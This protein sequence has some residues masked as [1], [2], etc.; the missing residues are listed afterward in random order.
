MSII[1]SDVE[2]Q[3]SLEKEPYTILTKRYKG[4]KKD[5]DVYR[6]FDSKFEKQLTNSKTKRQIGV[7]FIYKNGRAYL[8][9]PDY[10]TR[11]FHSCQGF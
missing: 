7:K 6:N 9:T 5:L 8:G 1:Y 4:I 2:R 11:I 10:C 3:Q